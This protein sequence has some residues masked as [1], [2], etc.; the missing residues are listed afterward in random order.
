[1]APH[2]VLPTDRVRHVGTAVAFVIAE[3]LAAAKDAAERIVVDYD[4][5][6]SNAL[7]MAEAPEVFLL[8]DNDELDIL[9][10]SPDESLRP[11]V[12]AAVRACPRQAIKIAD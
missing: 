3:S 9:I 7:C 12:E 2:D 6:E 11:K 4:L 8:K 10:E 1:M 5:C